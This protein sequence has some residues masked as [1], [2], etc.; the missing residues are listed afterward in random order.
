MDLMAS[1]LR[2]QKKG[3]FSPEQALFNI[4]IDDV[5]EGMESFISKF[6]DDTKLGVCVDLLEGRRALQKDLEW[7]DRWA[8]SNKFITKRKIDLILGIA[9]TVTPM[10]QLCSHRLLYHDNKYFIV[11][12]H[13]LQF[14]KNCSSVGHWTALIKT[15]KLEESLEQRCTLDGLGSG[16]TLL[17]AYLPMFGMKTVFLLLI[18]NM[19]LPDPSESFTFCPQE[20]W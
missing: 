12:L 15:Q 1:R 11:Y 9:A 2:W 10:S 5:D 7:L 4:F 3:R 19:S 8:E 18:L 6:A 13:Q 17:F 16:Q 14:L 20:N